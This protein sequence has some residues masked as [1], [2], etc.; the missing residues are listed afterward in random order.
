MPRLPRLT[1]DELL[2]VLRRAGWEQIRQRGSHV[3]LHRPGGGR[4]LVVPS[5]GKAL[6]TGT[7]AAIL[8]E[9]GIDAEE[10]ERWR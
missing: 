8:R 4:P 6:K 1:S 2:T 10:L 3:V 5:H 7:L 9:A